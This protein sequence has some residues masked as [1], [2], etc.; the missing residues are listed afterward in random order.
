MTSVS[1]SNIVILNINSADYLCIIIGICKREV[2]YLLQK[3][4]FKEKRAT[5]QNLKNLFLHIKLGREILM[6][7]DIEIK[8]QISAL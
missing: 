4:D 7:G 6:F 8:K 3:A 5:L 1:L 2:A